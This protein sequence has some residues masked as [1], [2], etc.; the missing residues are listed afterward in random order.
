MFPFGAALW[1]LEIDM[2]HR[3]A[4]LAGAVLGAMLAS[5]VMAAGEA[6][7]QHNRIFSLRQTDARTFLATDRNLRHFTIRLNSGCTGLSTG[8]ATPVFQPWQEL[9]C[10]RRGDVVGVASG[11]M[12]LVSCAIVAIEAVRGNTIDA[13]QSRFASLR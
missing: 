6:C 3:N 8:S 5:P 13:D 7:L 1:S 4:V 10:V 11:G 9:A 12:G 2:R